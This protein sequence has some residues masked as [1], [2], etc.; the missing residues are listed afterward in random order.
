M[1]IKCDREQNRIK[2]MAVDH[3]SLNPISADE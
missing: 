1:A 3:N 2:P